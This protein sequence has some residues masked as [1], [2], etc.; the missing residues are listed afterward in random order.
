MSFWDHHQKTI[1]INNFRGETHYL[2]GQKFYLFDEIYNY[3]KSLKKDWLSILKED[4]SF[5][6][7]TKTIDSIVVSRDLLDSIME[8]DFLEQNNLNLNSLNILDIGAGYGRLAHRISTAYPNA[9]V[10]CTDKIELSMELCQKYLDYNNLNKVN[11]VKP[12]NLA[13]LPKIDLAINIHSWP[14]CTR[15][16][17]NG[18]LDW[19]VQAK[20][21]YLFVIP[22][23]FNQPH[24]ACL[25][26][27]KSFLPDIQNHGYKIISH[28]HPLDC[29][30]RDY[31]LFELQCNA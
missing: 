27:G 6:V 9:S 20:V 4:G 29:F 10:Y 2:G 7:L 18:W 15:E 26:D 1:D 23:P 28:W 19:L 13:S 12:T 22:H 17:I 31:Y 16:D 3:V 11:I 14:E 30:P 8:L 21:K 5:G 25:E 24:F